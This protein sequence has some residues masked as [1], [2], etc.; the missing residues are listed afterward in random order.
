MI[1]IGLS[2]YV[3]AAGVQ[4]QLSSHIRSLFFWFIAVLEVE[5]VDRWP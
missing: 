5:D 2:E 1:T 3:H 4:S